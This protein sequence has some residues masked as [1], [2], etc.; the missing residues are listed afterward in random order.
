MTT[1]TEK[2]K[3]IILGGSYAG[4]STAHYILKH[5]LPKLSSSSYQVLLISTTSQTMC[6]PAAPRAIIS[7]DMFDQKKLF[8]DIAGC[9][10]QYTNND[11]DGLFKFMQ[12]TA[13]F[14]DH[15]ASTV[16]IRCGGQVKGEIVVKYHALIIATGSTTYSPL[17]GFTTDE[18]ALRDNWTTFRHKLNTPDLR[19]IVIAGGGASGVE[20]AGELAEYLSLSKRNVRITLLSG[21]KRL[22]PYLRADMAKTAETYLSRLDVE[23]VHNLRVAVVGTDTG[24]T[25]DNGEVWN[26]DL[27]IPAVGARPNTEFVADVLRTKDGRVDADPETLRVRRAGDRVFAIGDCA[28]AARPAI[29]NIM[30][31][32]PVLGANIKRDLLLAEGQVAGVDRLFREDTRMTQLVP[33]GRSKGVGAVMGWRVPS[34]L[35]WLIK[36]RDYWLWTT[37]NLW[38]GKQWAKE[39]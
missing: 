36:G 8:V 33:I 25:L 23:V 7:D 15:G 16:V 18:E 24:L 1:A 9:F 38:S 35:V 30:A 13:T 3:L 17:L 28:S 20:T 29:H 19:H 5:V 27:Y 31:M 10:A 32:V 6:R 12:G 11:D 4:I 22:L 2:K 26:V 21:G 39:S 37:G 14:L 34:F